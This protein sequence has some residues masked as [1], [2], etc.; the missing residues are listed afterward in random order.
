MVDGLKR[1]SQA[2]QAAYEALEITNRRVEID[3]ERQHSLRLIFENETIAQREEMAKKIFQTQ[4]VLEEDVVEEAKLNKLYDGVRSAVANT[5]NFLKHK[6]SEENMANLESLRA[7]LG[8][9]FE[10]AMD[11]QFMDVALGSM[12]LDSV[13]LTVEKEY[14]T[15]ATKWLNSPGD[16]KDLKVDDYPLA[17]EKAMLSKIHTI[18]RMD[19][20]SSKFHIR[21]TS[22]PTSERNRGGSRTGQYDLA[23]PTSCFGDSDIGVLLLARKHGQDA[24]PDGGVVPGRLCSACRDSSLPRQQNYR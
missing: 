15:R 4:G 11:L 24:E 2:W 7:H 3:C 10:A 8:F 17:L 20:D 21:S 16:A 14:Y 12:L 6:L 23:N 18:R 19:F 5:I 9:D 22:T 13:L 1:Q